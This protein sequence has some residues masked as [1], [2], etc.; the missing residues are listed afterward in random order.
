VSPVSHTPATAPRIAG[1]DPVST[2]SDVLAEIAT[3]GLHHRDVPAPG[4]PAE[5]SACLDSGDRV[6]ADAT[7]VADT[8]GIV[9]RE[10]VCLRH[11][12]DLAAFHAA[13]HAATVVTV[14]V[15]TPRRPTRAQRAAALAQRARAAT[16]TPDPAVLAALVADLA[17]EL[18]TLARAADGTL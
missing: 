5:C 4:V 14:E 17:A 8:R 12:A 16:A 9:Y 15:P 18:A 11:L 2:R 7:L 13:L 6:D 10:P 1:P 3:L